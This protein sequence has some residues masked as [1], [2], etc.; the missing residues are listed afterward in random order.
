MNMSTLAILA[1]SS[2]ALIISIYDLLRIIGFTKIDQKPS[3]D[4]K[5]NQRVSLVIAPLVVLMA[6]SCVAVLL[7]RQINDNSALSDLMSM[8]GITLTITGT[9]ITLITIITALQNYDREK[10]DKELEDKILKDLDE[11][12]NELEQFKKDIKAESESS[13]KKL[14]EGFEAAVND[15]KK[16]LNDAGE[17]IAEQNKIYE[18]MRKDL[19]D[20]IRVLFD[21]NSDD[22]IHLRIRIENYRKLLKENPQSV[23]VALAL[24]D[25]LAKRVHADTDEDQMRE[26]DEIITIADQFIERGDIEPLE[27]INLSIKKA[28]AS[29]GNGRLTV[30]STNAELKAKASG[31]Y[32]DALAIYHMLL[33]DIEVPKTLTG[34]LHGYLG[35]CYYWKYR[36]SEHNQDVQSLD[37]SIRHY[38]Q[39]VLSQPNDAKMLNSLAVSKQNRARIIENLEERI[40]ALDDVKKDYKLAIAADPRRQKSWL[41]IAAVD[42]DIIHL[43][44]NVDIRKKD[45]V[46]EIP[47][48]E[49]AARIKKLYSEG[50][51]HIEKAM[52][53]NPGLIDLYFKYADLA[54]CCA[55]VSDDEE[56]QSLLAEAKKRLEYGTLLDKDSKQ[57]QMVKNLYEACIRFF[58]GQN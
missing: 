5:V 8:Q 54:C 41:N 13:Q 20:N 15:N 51:E 49:T 32:D 43:L 44:L 55:I 36:A 14:T 10:K 28:N 29:Y 35:L 2:L 58:N 6:V 11:R 40:T 50:V 56:R 48:Q 26:N 53:I 4:Q 19:S 52:M 27:R 12:K 37:E 33:N 16:F 45:I 7:Y 39:C 18:S 57:L 31:Y 30:D 23:N 22:D 46:I 3:G 1:I 9:A 42:S 34:Y 47:D 24:M 21:S 25:A 38:Q 17:K